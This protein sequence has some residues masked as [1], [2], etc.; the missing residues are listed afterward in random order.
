MEDWDDCDA[1]LV[2]TIRLPPAAAPTNIK[3]F[4]IFA[5]SIDGIKSDLIPGP[6]PKKRL[7]TSVS[8]RPKP[9]LNITIHPAHIAPRVPLRPFADDGEWLLPPSLRLAARNLLSHSDVLAAQQTVRNALPYFFYGAQMFPAILRDSIGIKRKSLKDM[10]A[11]MTPAYVSGCRREGLEGRAWPAAYRT[12][13][14][15][16]SIIGMLAFGLPQYSQE[17][18]DKFQ[19]GSSSRQIMK[20]KFNLRDGSICEVDCYVYVSTQQSTQQSEYRPWCIS[21]LMEDSWHLQNLALS[22][23][24]ESVLRPELSEP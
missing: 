5:S 23:A 8:P 16:D 19:G 6:P 17:A 21:E 10:I 14:S 22:E 11:Q 7:V 1:P 20:A 3:D 24:E 15:E 13:R 18:L 4:C 12:D 9:Q 2:E